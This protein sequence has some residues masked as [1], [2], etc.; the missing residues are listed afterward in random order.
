MALNIDDVFLCHL[1]RS[2]N[3]LTYFKQQPKMVSSLDSYSKAVRFHSNP[4]DLETT[5]ILLHFVSKLDGIEHGAFACHRL[6]TSFFARE[7]F[8]DHLH[9]LNRL[10]SNHFGMFIRII[11]GD[12]CNRKFVQFTNNWEQRKTISS[13]RRGNLGWPIKGI[14]MVKRPCLINL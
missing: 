9:C 13:R 3:E 8:F 7:T 6:H 5:Y 10:S 1:I 12:T 11:I 14:M 4:F 2:A